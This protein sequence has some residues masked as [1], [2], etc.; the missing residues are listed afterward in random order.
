MMGGGGVGRFEHVDIVVR[1]DIVSAVS[2]YE[3]GEMVRVRVLNKDKEPT[4]AWTKRRQ[5]LL[6]P[7]FPPGATLSPYEVRAVGPD[8]GACTTFTHVH[9]KAY[10]V[11]RNGTVTCKNKDGK[12]FSVLQKGQL[13]TLPIQGTCFS[14][15]WVVGLQGIKTERRKTGILP[16]AHPIMRVDVSELEGSPRVADWKKG[17]AGLD[18][19]D[20]HRILREDRD[21]IQDLDREESTWMDNGMHW[22]AW[23]ILGGALLGMS[24]A[25]LIWYKCKRRDQTPQEDIEME[26]SRLEGRLI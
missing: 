1:D 5:Y 19:E 7:D 26:P 24:M 2:E 6:D 22:L 20:M 14:A 11:W 15:C 12:K 9:G 23:A 10:R 25:S 18:F 16:A 17:G 4:E 21:M 3:T 8:T 13:F